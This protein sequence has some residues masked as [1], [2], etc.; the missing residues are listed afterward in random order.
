MSGAARKAQPRI[1]ARERGP[2][3]LIALH[4]AGDIDTKAKRDAVAEQIADDVIEAI[5]ADR[6]A[7]GLPPLDP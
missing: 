1:D 6:K 2:R 7:N 4:G 3:E 5:E